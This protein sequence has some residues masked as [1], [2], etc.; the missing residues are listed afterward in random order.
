MA[1][2]GTVPRVAIKNIVVT[3]DFSP[4]SERAL[5]YATWIARYYGSRIHLV[6]PVEAAHVHVT[7][8]GQ[9]AEP[10]AGEK[11][12]HQAEKCD[13]IKCLQWVLKGTAL[14]V[15]ERMLS[16]DQIDLVVIGTHAGKGFRKLAIGSAA[17][18][19]FRNIHCPVLAVGPAVS[20]RH[21]W[22]PRRVLLTTDLQSDESMASRC[23]VF[24]AREHGAQ[25]ALLH[26]A[27]PVPAPYP[28]EQQVAARLYFQSRL[29]ELLSYKPSLDYPAEFWVEFGEDA[30]AQ[31]LHV[32]QERAI[33][34]VVLS[35]HR[36]EPWGLH[37][38]RHAYRIVAEAACP[39]LITQRKY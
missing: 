17:E 4:A 36:E 13:E 11:L 33:D 18:H 29:R 26:V 38:V 15:V 3:T 31:I 32:V 37:L 35:V 6:H 21:A 5:D 10:E 27:P 19:F 22:E 16:L 20:R 14:D 12:R 34:L 39:V 24:L 7:P 2:L 30:V 8:E 1:V 23:A 9:D 28:D 25:L